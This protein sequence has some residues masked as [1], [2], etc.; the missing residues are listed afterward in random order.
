MYAIHLRSILVFK[1]ISGPWETDRKDV[2]RLEQIRFYHPTIATISRLHFY[3]K[4]KQS[5][6]LGHD[7]AS[8]TFIIV[9]LFSS[10]VT[11]P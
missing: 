9:V 11:Y 8:S 1:V 10:P 4:N 7:L 5:E 3:I 2:L 6:N